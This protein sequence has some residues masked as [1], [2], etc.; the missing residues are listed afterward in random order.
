MKGYEEYLQEAGLPE[1]FVES[2]K[3]LCYY[4]YLVGLHLPWV[5]C[6]LR[7]DEHV[8]VY[9]RL[10]TTINAMQQVAYK[11]VKIREEVTATMYDYLTSDITAY[12]LPFVLKASIKEEQLRALRAYKWKFEAVYGILLDH[13][14]A[15]AGNP[16]K[17]ELVSVTQSG[18]GMKFHSLRS[19]N[20]LLTYTNCGEI[21]EEN[22]A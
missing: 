19:G 9:K 18:V 21:L 4:A 11:Y 20:R 22:C 2:E 8:K 16:D 15:H 17:V 12:C 5:L 13:F 3:K 14:R 7:N 6:K 1:I 10:I